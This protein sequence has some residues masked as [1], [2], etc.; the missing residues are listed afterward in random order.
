MPTTLGA[1]APE[2]SPDPA[3][4]PIDGQS[5]DTVP[6]QSSTTTTVAGGALDGR[7]TVGHGSQARYGIDDIV[8]GQKQ[9]VVGSTDQVSGDLVIAESTVQSANAVVDMRSVR[10]DCVH[11]DKY[12]DLLDTDRYPT[13]SFELATPIP[14]SSI[15]GTARS[16]GSR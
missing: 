12:Q 6:P 15:P 13:S 9:R 7:W 4:A 16:C 5:A 14:L 2:P 1:S 8:L 11:D 3:A 10:C